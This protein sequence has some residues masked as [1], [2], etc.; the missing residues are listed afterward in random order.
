MKSARRYNDLVKR[1]AEESNS[2]ISVGYDPAPADFPIAGISGY[3]TNLP[4]PTDDYDKQ[5]LKKYLCDYFTEFLHELRNNSSSASAFKFN[6]GYF[7]M[8]DEIGTPVGSKALR[9]ILKE[10]G[11]SDNT[12]T[13]LDVKDADIARSSA[14]YA[15]SKLKSNWIDA[16]TV[17]PYM[18]TDSVEPFFD[19]AHGREQGVYVLTRTTNPGAEDIQ[20]LTVSRQGDST[21]KLYMET[22]EKIVDWSQDYTGTV[23]SV[24]A[25]N[26]LQELRE[27]AELFT[28]HSAAIPLLIPGVGTQ[29]GK[30]DQVVDVLKEVGYDPRLAKISSS[31]GIMYR[32]QKDGVDSERHA[33]AS[34][35]EVQRLNAQIGSF[36]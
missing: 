3:D 26:N 34:V 32:A 9:T 25:G 19:F 12:V 8:Y 33:R 1:S 7:R 31:S 23:G 10:V 5:S 14:A 29:G 18:G 30:A 2:I 35:E 6:L 28:E 15:I 11:N 20:N 36:Y 21:N 17:S 24:V 27:V 4:S 22:A 13:I 16:I